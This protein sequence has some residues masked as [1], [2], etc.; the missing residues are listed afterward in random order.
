MVNARV[1]WLGKRPV[2]FEIE[3]HADQAE[4]GYDVICAAVSVLGQTTLVSLNEIAG[5]ENLNY[6]IEDGY[7]RCQLPALL[8]E[9]QEEIA[10]ILVE[11]LVLGIRG[12]A[13][14]APDV[15][16]LLIE[17]VESDAYQI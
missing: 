10:R 7:L 1:G 5:I 15:V 4:Y 6:A 17:E 9:A 8:T 13:E 16:K 2:Y 11:S 3:G 12:V 14:D